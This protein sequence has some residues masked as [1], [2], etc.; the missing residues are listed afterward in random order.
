MKYIDI[1]THNEKKCA[2]TEVVNLFAHEVNLISGV[3]HC[4]IGFHP[5]HIGQYDE[6]EM[7]NNLH[8]FANFPQVLAIGECGIDIAITD[9]L[10]QERI[11]LKQAG[12]AENI[13]KPLIIHCVRAYNE[14]IRLRKLIHAKMPWIIHGFNGN[15][16]QADQLVKNGFYLSFGEKLMFSEQLMDVF[17]SVPTEKIF[18]E[19]DEGKASI[20]EIYSFVSGILKMDIE[21][22]KTKI[23]ENFKYVFLHG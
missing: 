8:E 23:N 7:I 22:L 19:T 14:I 2:E 15:K 10:A 9:I 3:H 16:E 6:S 12:I 21:D 20:R 4:S 18:F 1:H 5:W 13:K 11:F 17:L